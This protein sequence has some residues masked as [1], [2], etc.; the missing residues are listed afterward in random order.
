MMHRCQTKL[1]RSKKTVLLNKNLNKQK[2]NV[3]ISSERAYLLSAGR[4]A[5]YTCQCNCQLCTERNTLPL[6]STSKRF[7]GS[8]C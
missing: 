2:E 6:A 4:L 1:N 5:V 7:Q 3:D 8:T